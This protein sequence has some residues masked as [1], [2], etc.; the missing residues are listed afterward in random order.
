M[1]KARWSLLTLPFSIM[2][3]EINSEYSRPNQ[4]VCGSPSM[5]RGCLSVS[6][7]LF[8][9]IVLLFCRDS[10]EQAKVMIDVL[11]NLCVI[12][13]HKV[14]LRKLNFVCSK[15]VPPTMKDGIEGIMSIKCTSCIGKYLGFNPVIEW[16]TAGDFNNVVVKIQ[17]K[18]ASWKWKLLNRAGR[19]RLTNSVL[20]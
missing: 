13:S 4:E 6:H 16:V 15:G 8:V 2:H 10:H 19:L 18:F 9:D 1:P 7:L 14:N 3:G 20:A 11:D 17:S 5:S 12:S